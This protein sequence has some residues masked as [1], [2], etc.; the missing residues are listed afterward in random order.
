MAPFLVSLIPCADAILWVEDQSGHSPCP[1]P[2]V[3]IQGFLLKS[4]ASFDLRHWHSTAAT[5]NL[6]QRIA[7]VDT[8][9]RDVQNMS[10]DD[11]HT[12]RGPGCKL[13]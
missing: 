8:S 10:P 2:G 1:V 4:P 13:E 11:R 12:L 6:R 3:N 7:V 5:S 9:V